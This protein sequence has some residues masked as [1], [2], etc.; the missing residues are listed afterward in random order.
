MI[1]LSPL[2]LLLFLTWSTAVFAQSAADLFNGDALQ[3]IRL[4]IHPKD[5]ETLKATPGSNAYYPCDLKWRGLLVE[6]IG[7]RQRGGSTRNE[8]KPGLRIDFNRYE[9]Q[10][11]FLGLKSLA[12]DN[13]A[14]DASMMK[15][16]LTMELFSKVGL[17]APREV[18]ARL[19]VNGVYT[20]LY[21]LIEPIDK[22][23]LQAY[24]GED[25]GYLYEYQSPTSY[26]F[27]YLG[28]DPALYSPHFFDPKTHEKDPDPAPI[29]AM[30]RTMNTASDAGFASAMAPYLD[31]QLFMKHLAVEDFIAETDGILT[32]MNN[33]YLYR[34]EKKTLSQF[35]VKD[36]DLTFGGTFNKTARYSSPFLVN[37]SKNVL[38]RRAMNL[39]EARDAYFKTLGN[40]VAIADANGWLAS[41]ITRI[42]NQIRS[43]V[44]E[45]TFKLCYDGVVQRPCADAEFE[46]EVA[47]N[48]E[49]ARR[50]PGFA[51]NQLAQLSTESFF[52]INDLGGYS[53]TKGDVA[54]VIY[55]GYGVIEPDA[56]SPNPEGIAT[57]TYRQNGVTVTEASVPASAALQ[58][59]VLYA[60]INGPVKTGLAIANPSDETAVISFFYTDAD[61]TAFGQSSFF[62]SARGQMARFLDEDPFKSAALVR[63]TFTFDSSVPV[64]VTALR[65]LVNERSEFIISTLPVA[66]LTTIRGTIIIP[67][68]ADG[69]GWTTQAILVNPS[70]QPM[71]GS[72]QFLD[73]GNL[74]ASS[75]TIA[76]GSHYR[77]QTSNS[78][79]TIRAGS[80]RIVPATNSDGPAAFAIFSFRK[81][82]FTVSEASVRAVRATS[83]YRTYVET[84]AN[85]QTGIALANPSS[86]PITINLEATTLS[87]K[88]AGLSGAVTIPA[89]G[90]VAAFL[91]QI[92]GFEGMT[93]PF[94]GVL[95]V[96]TTALS[97]VAVAGLRGRNN[98]RGDFL[99]ATVPSVDESAATA[100]TPLAFP[101]FVEGGGYTTQFVLFSGTSRSFATG[102]LRLFDPTGR[103]INAW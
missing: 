39:Q 38:I 84:A 81:D 53:L 77:V 83:A 34:F 78:G 19:Y 51:L 69:G 3:E 103:S 93:A 48:L 59:G 64:F 87:G 32:G 85:I 45:D 91:G 57:F 55:S 58:H 54:K 11:E 90:H 73:Q 86:S 35:I 52:A 31:L 5:W 18:N 72:I 94:Q 8:T 74:T 29:E 46:A 37:A 102:V 43:A 21:T 88:P 42:Y 65:G 16:R 9:A 6:N 24:Y 80:V 98:E 82:G 2:V 33:F 44:Y 63:G 30:I 15:E 41:E 75:Y 36:K 47:A 89:N 71:Q 23:F 56:G 62:L 92:P 14:Q 95:R 61:G 25:D 27:E 17:P 79:D 26:H 49:F 76:P 22:N 13:M 7:I 50:R 4:E 70:S 97:G 67:H 12:L 20:G 99:I 96:S 60:E 100:K 10:Q 1:N 28:S 40:L 101:H 68:F 66:D